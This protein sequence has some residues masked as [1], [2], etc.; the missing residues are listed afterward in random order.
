[1]VGEKAMEI[2]DFGKDSGGG[3][4]RDNVSY[5]DMSKSEK[6]ALY[7]FFL[8][9]TAGTIGFLY[10]A[11]WYLVFSNTGGKDFLSVTSTVCGLLTLVSFLLSISGIVIGG[12][13][14]NQGAGINKDRAIMGIVGGAL[15]W[16]FLGIHLLIV[17]LVGASYFG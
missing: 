5:S 8:G 1:M 7:S 14:L 17:V 13:S 16:L 11:L 6:Q 2:G 3:E 4:S 15:Y 12:I 9:T 10:L